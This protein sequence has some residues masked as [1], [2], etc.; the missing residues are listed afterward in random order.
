MSEYR[1]GPCRLFASGSGCRFGNRCK[2]SH[3]ISSGTPSSSQRTGSP[4]PSHGYASQPRTGSQSGA[5]PRVC[6]LYWNTGS[7]ARA[8]ECS[9]KHERK[10]VAATSVEAIPALSTEEEESP[11]FFSPEGLAMHNGS[12]REER[13][14]LTPSE[15]HNHIKPFLADNYR[16]D[17]A[18]RV[19]G[20]VRILASVN[21]RNKAWNSDS[22]QAFLDVVVNG[23]A[24]LRI[25]DV[26]R[27][28]PVNYM[29]GHGNGALSFQKGYFPIF[30]YF[31]SNLVLKSTL[32]KNINVIEQ[33]IG[34]MVQTKSWQ[35]PTPNLPPTLQSSLS[36]VVVFKTLTT[37]LLQFFNRFKDAIR[38]HPNIVNLVNNLATWFEIWSSDV[39]AIPA[40]FLDTI[41]SSQAHVRK[42]TLSQLKNEVDR[43]QQIVQRESDA[44][45]RKR[46]PAAPVRMS[47]AQRREALLAQLAQ[48]YD[49]PGELRSGGS[50]HD[51]DKED[52]ADI[53]N[54]P[55]ND[56]LLCAVP[57]YLPVFLPDAPHHLPVGSMERHLDI[58]FRLLREDLIATMR[59]SIA[60][61]HS[62]LAAV[63]QSGT[64]QRVRT[65]LEELLASKGGAYR[66]SG[67][68]SVFFQ[69]YTGIEFA[70]VRAERRDLTVGL[71]L[72]TPNH[73]AARDKD[74]KKRY[75]YWEHS[76][77]L[78][79]GTLVALVVVTH[80]TLRIFLGVITSFNK[81]IAESSR[82]GPDTVQIRISFF[83]AEVEF[84]ALRQEKVSVDASTFAVLID[85]SVMFDAARPFLERLQTIE[86]TE[87]PFARYITHSGSLEDVELRS[88]RFATAPGFRYKLESLAKP[89]HAGRIQPL[90]LSAEGGIDGARRQLLASSI[91][92]QSQVDALVNTLTREVS[93]IQG[94]P[95]TGKS[96]TAKEI[97]RVLFASGIR[98]ID[99]GITKKFV[100][101]GSRSSDERIAEFT[102]DKLEKIAG[103]QNMLERPIKRQYATMKKLEEDMVKVM[104]SIQLPELNWEEIQKF[105]LIHYPDHAES[106]EAPPFWITMLREKI[107][108]DERTDGEWQKAGKK[109]QADN[110]LAHTIYSFWREGR[111]LEFISP[112]VQPRSKNKN[113]KGKA[114]APEAPADSTVQTFFDSLGFDSSPPIP[115]T[116]R[117]L[118]YLFESGNIWSMSIT[119]RC[120]LAADWEQNIRR[121]A[122]TSNLQHYEQ[123]RT[124]YKAACKEYQDIRDENISP[125]V[126]MVEEA[127]QVL[128]AHVLTSLV[129]SVDQLICIGDPQQLRPN[130]ATYALSMDSERGKQL[131]KFDRSLMERLANNGLPMSQINVQRR[132]RPTISHFIRQILYPKLEDNEIVFGY[133]H[134]QGMQKDVYFYSHTNKENGA[135]DSVS[136][137][138]AFEVDMIRDLVLY[139]LK[140][141][142][143]NGPGDIAVLC[144]YLG[145]LQKVRAALRDLKI[146]VSLDERDQEQLARQGIDEEP[147]F[148]EVFVTKHVRLGT[149][150]IFQG[151]EAKIVI[152]SLVRNSGTYETGSA[153]IGFLKSSNR[154]NVALSRA[155]HG[156]F[157]L[158][159]AANLRKNDTWSTIIDEMEVREEVGQGFPIVCP[160]HPE[161]TQLIT[162]PGELPRLAPGGGCLLPCGYRLSCGHNCPSSCHAA[163]DNHRSTKCNE[164]CNRTPCPRG[165]P[166]SRRCW[167]DCGD[168]EFPVYGITLPCGHVKDRIACHMLDKLEKI[169]CRV[170]VR[171]PLLRCEHTAEMSCCQDGSSIRCKELCGEALTCC[172]KTCKSA[173]SDCQAATV[174]PALSATKTPTKTPPINYQ[175]PPTC[176]T[177]RGPIT[178]LRYGRVNKRATLDILEQNVAGTMSRALDNISPL[179]EQAASNFDGMQNAAKELKAQMEDVSAP[180]PT[181][182]PHG[183]STAPLDPDLLG[184]GALQSVHGFHRDEAKGW[185]AIVKDLITGYRKTVKVANTRGAHVKAYEAALATL[186]RL[187][188]EAIACDPERASDAPEPLAMKSVN[189]KIG[190]PPH[191][192]DTRFQIEAY[193]LSLEV[194]LMLAQ[195]GVSRIANLPLGSDSESVMNHR[196]LWISFV[197]FI[198][199]SCLADA[200]KALYMAQKSSASRQAAKC[201]T[202]ILRSEFEYFRVDIVEERSK[203][204]SG[205]A[206]NEA[207]RKELGERVKEKSRY[208]LEFMKKAA[209]EY[210]RSRSSNT[211]EE[212]LAEMEW[213][214]TNCMRKVVRWRE[215]CDELEK[216]V[217]RVGTFYQPITLQERQD[218]VKALDFATRGH[219]YNCE[220]GH[221]FVIGECGG[222]METARCPECGAAIGGS[223][224]RLI[225]SNTRATEFEEILRGGGARPGYVDLMG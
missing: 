97:L 147:E 213:F 173:C 46:R 80:R 26:L 79:S 103:G 50:R 215:D 128:E 179:M 57:P 66:T 41:V 91:L 162:K 81:D 48:T 201:S 198:F 156:L 44:A 194:R 107:E 210:I 120:R 119:E 35:D 11:D 73:R 72:D 170:K 94:P 184:V 186:Y 31:A 214:E 78:Q 121:L 169:I 6:N 129:Q 106:F 220:N 144:A 4:S 111:D 99:A 189:A 192:A 174:G 90:S 76:K 219:F 160:R 22:A 64:Q 18:S 193:I 20:F 9:F 59:S 157:I 7:C 68:D 165:H 197:A 124:Q 209:E 217:T 1:P 146:S 139:F 181:R 148:E 24:I 161:Q 133:P 40:R 67:F 45:E 130:L 38:N 182:S 82:G 95:G 96:F 115:T 131:F 178:A 116:D 55:T 8:F 180:S 211:Q 63:W 84:M 188:L 56:E 175:T 202:Y 71:V 77:R 191:K 122:Y 69:L 51:N 195:V 105:L 159:N 164:A 110:A 32:H 21:D 30:G 5:P 42:L 142:S 28:Q 152:V 118:K 206:Y 114:K 108:E 60:A 208:M 23:N 132:M 43:L 61:V 207:N 34:G 163:L 176:P 205:G 223:S 49:P 212:L 37:V 101:L 13:H 225:S 151:Q 74:A 154:I 100:R 172:S 15:A 185:Q 203:R 218:I 113:K 134:V 102:L 89:D 135:E 14:A 224:H 126:L 221:T 36:G 127:G 155:K 93:L 16:F 150:D 199:E 153:S 145:Q 190:Q 104:T 92:D 168:C 62:D 17:N 86:P 158:G 171:R 54:A 27:F 29:I 125:K 39:S 3:D 123:L 98:P 2:F 137:F 196:Q 117:S 85:N 222:A 177:C 47:A 200:R 136:K 87:I 53:R 166:C 52:I 204:M 25:G 58:Q 10:P 19:Q 70:P 216:F 88:P 109:K 112:P 12:V 33:C 149:V 83:D 143:Y 187:E 141:G 140:Q 138:N 75:D 183:K 65:K 167:E